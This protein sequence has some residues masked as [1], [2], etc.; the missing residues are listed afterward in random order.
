MGLLAMDFLSIIA[1]GLIGLFAITLAIGLFAAI[2]LNMKVGIRFREK[3]A[4]RVADLRLGKM[5]SALGIDIDDYLH[6]ERV[7][8][9][10]NH[11]KRCAQCANTDECDDKLADNTI[12][13]HQIA[14][15]NNEKSLR[16]L[17]GNTAETPASP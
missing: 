10:E 12:K 1:V 5:L 3:L 16:E 4:S 17:V 9:I 15:C 13:A 2:F 11:I 7:T 8:D 14:F 6:S